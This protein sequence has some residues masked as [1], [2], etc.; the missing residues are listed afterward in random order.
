MSNVKSFINVKGMTAHCKFKSL[1]TSD[2]TGKMMSHIQ[3]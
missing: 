2:A 3:N 1:N